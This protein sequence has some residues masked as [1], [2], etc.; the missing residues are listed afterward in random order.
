MNI[1]D[2]AKL[3]NVSI[4]T[5]SRVVN[6]SPN[7]SEKTKKKVLE[8]ME[9]EGYTPNAFA[10]SLGLGSMK[11]IGIVCPDVSDLYMARAVGA[12][13]EELKQY[14]YQTLLMCSGYKQEQKEECVQ[15]L[16]SKKVDA[17][18]LIGSTYADDGNASKKTSYIEETAKSVPVFLV[19]GSLPYENVYTA[20]CDD[21]QS[22]YEATTALL[23][24]N[25]TNI[26]FLHNSNSYSAIQKM[27]G[28][29]QALR[30]HNQP[31]LGEMKVFVK[32]EIYHVRDLFLTKKDI[33]FDGVVATEDSLAVGI[34]KYAKAAQINVPKDLK[35]IGYNN[36]FL[37]ECCEPELSSVDSKG[38]ELC[39]YTIEKLLGVLGGSEEVEGEICL[40]GELIRRCTTDF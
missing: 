4:A 1:Y 10:R 39:R 5:V 34:L 18:I 9:C 31:V 14:E 8:I 35:V 30:D 23:N 37:A 20:C 16:M 32:N 33:V 27:H 21:Y 28:Y 17:L 7:V 3:A 24:H 26:L 2:I 11:T 25:C 19:N 6:N 38:K 15:V 12:I 29:E 22:T 13:E 40:Q 36:S